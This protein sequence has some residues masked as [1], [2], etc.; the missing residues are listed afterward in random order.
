[1]ASLGLLLLQAE[2]CPTLDASPNPKDN[3]AIIFLSLT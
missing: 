2:L 1:L 3:G